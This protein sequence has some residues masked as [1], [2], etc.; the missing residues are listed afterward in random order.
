M[1][2]VAESGVLHQGVSDHSFIYA[3]YKIKKEKG[4]PYINTIKD[5]K[6][7]D[8][9]KLKTRSEQTPWSPCSIFDE[10][11]DCVWIWESLYRDIIKDEIPERKAKVRRKS[12][13]WV[14]TDIRKLMNKRYKTLNQYTKTKSKDDWTEYQRLRN[15][16]SKK[17][18]KAEAEYWCSA[19]KE[20]KNTKEF[21]TL[22]KRVKTPMLTQT[23]EHYRLM[24]N[25][26]LIPH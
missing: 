17:L 6:G 15:M 9:E 7:A 4:L 22:T 3:C 5:F 26:L 16:V 10:I 8:M 25:S 1:E 20:V 19:F 21:W 24:R 18:R 2:K 14:T 13:P 12:L 11:D 23:Y